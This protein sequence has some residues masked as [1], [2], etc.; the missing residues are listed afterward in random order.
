M[1]GRGIRHSWAALALIASALVSLPALAAVEGPCC[2]A[3]DAPGCTN[4]TTEAE[5]CAA[6]AYCC[7]TRWDGICANAARSGG[8]CGYTC[9]EATTVTGC[10]DAAV[11][12]CVC[13]A[14]PFCCNT[15]WDSLC[16]QRAAGSC[17]ACARLTA[18]ECADGDF[19]DS[20]CGEAAIAA[21]S[22]DPQ[23]TC[24]VGLEAMAQ[25]RATQLQNL[26]GT[27]P[28]LRTSLVNASGVVT[29]VDGSWETADALTE[30]PAG[31]V[32]ESTLGDGSLW[33]IV[34][35][36]AARQPWYG[37]FYRVADCAE[38]SYEKHFDY[39]EFEYRARNLGEDWRA[40]YDLAWGSKYLKHSVASRTVYGTG[41]Y[42]KRGTAAPQLK[43]ATYGTAKNAFFA[44]P[45]VVMH[46]LEERPRL[47]ETPWGGVTHRPNGWDR[48]QPA[49]DIR[50]TK[51]LAWHK[52]MSEL[53]AGELD[54]RLL[55]FDQ[56]QRELERLV[57]VAK[58]LVELRNK[59]DLC[60]SS[61][62]CYSYPSACSAWYCQPAARAQL[63]A[64]AEAAVAAVEEA[65]FTADAEGCLGTAP[66]PCDWS[67]RLFAE[68][69]MGQMIASREEAWDQ[70]L[71]MVESITPTLPVGESFSFAEVHFAWP[72]TSRPIGCADGDYGVSTVT[73]DQLIAC[74]ATRKSLWQSY[75]K[76]AI[77][78]STSASGDLRTAGSAGESRSAGNDYFAVSYGYDSR[79]N[80]SGYAANICQTQIETEASFDAH[81]TAF[82]D[83]YPLMT[84]DL[85]MDG[86]GSAKV[87][88]RLFGDDVYTGGDKQLW[89]KGA[90]FSVVRASDEPTETHRQEIFNTTIPILG[91]PVRLVGGLSG[92]V[93]VRYA[94]EAEASRCT[95]QGG[96]VRLTLDSAFEPFAGIAGF[97]EA[98][99][100]FL[101]LEVGVKS[102]L[103]LLEAA[104]PLDA[105]VTVRR[106][107]TTG[108]HELDASVSGRLELR[109][110]SGHIK[111]YAE[112]LWNEVEKTL[113]Q[114]PGFTRSW[115]LF[116]AGFRLPLE[117]L[118][119]ACGTIVDCG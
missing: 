28:V 104:L 102:R 69:V 4:P 43:Q 84:A 90:S 1:R 46:A 85:D 88:F 18:G 14:D 83:D 81:V 119:D 66:G 21:A 6:D 16:A 9:S 15:R 61:T 114:W 22:G 82:G 91:V 45:D 105:R 7:S 17:G 48:L 87:R 96:T 50:T 55:Y 2:V 109:T 56:Q 12:A 65:I 79:W 26:S 115:A 99:V 30:T 117:V 39:S 72:P 23:H 41:L 27:R 113:V 74:E 57:D 95:T 80:V 38:Y 29:P 86:L 35:S 52:Q 11:Q 47:V 49:L 118:Q 103:T 71:A 59:A 20:A 94:L 19:L 89:S 75:I 101:V 77:A 60:P 37:N 8:Y 33:A 78:A 24:N 100:D 67:P 10:L 108:T 98:A 110:L 25:D 44:I 64:D 68:A 62:F 32:T 31:A 92:Q 111:V 53:L 63:E 58:P 3:G 106:S 13:Q 34:G 107:G 54:E 93:G 51:N 36:A 70:C 112:A 76:Q 116:D 5:I 40:I 73:V 42:T 97:A